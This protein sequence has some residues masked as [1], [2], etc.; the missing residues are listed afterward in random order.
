MPADDLA[1]CATR[2]SAA[3]LLTMHGKQVIVLHQEGF[4]LHAPC[5]C[6]E[7][8]GQCKY[9]FFFI[10]LTHCSLV[11]SY[12]DIYLGQH[13]LTIIVCYLTAQW[14]IA[15]CVENSTLVVQFYCRQ[16]ISK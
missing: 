8:I 15:L 12:G 6:G 1:P 2:S 5:Q 16:K 4:L 7:I 3:M 9:V 11:T 13:W 10:F 14:L